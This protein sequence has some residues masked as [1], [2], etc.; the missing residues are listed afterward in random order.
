MK[1]FF[2]NLEIDCDDNSYPS[3]ERQ[4][5]W[6]LQ[7]LQDQLDELKEKGELRRYK[8]DGIRFTDD[9]IRYA[10][11]QWFK[12]IIDL[13]RAI[14]LTISDLYSKYNIEVEIADEH[15]T[16]DI[17]PAEQLCLNELLVASKNNK[18]LKAA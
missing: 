15:T 16:H 6:R 5:M 12:R 3:P 7:D 18:T 13:E 14:E 17:L 8:D 2:P 11:P 4:L 1:Y 10:I 9:N